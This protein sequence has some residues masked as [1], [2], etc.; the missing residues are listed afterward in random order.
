MARTTY[1]AQTKRAVSTKVKTDSMAVS[2]L[3][4]PPDQKRSQRASTFQPEADPPLAED[5]SWRSV[6]IAVHDWYLG[7]TPLEEQR[8]RA[9][10]FIPTFCVGRLHFVSAPPNSGGSGSSEEFG[11]AMIRILNANRRELA[12]PVTHDRSLVL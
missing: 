4:M 5:L 11:V 7:V 10:E 3:A 9:A 1:S 2:G 8:G 12:M 6:S